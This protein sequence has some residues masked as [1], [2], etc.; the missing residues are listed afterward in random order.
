MEPGK[1]LLGLPPLKYIYHFI[2]EF[3]FAKG[4]GTGRESE[5]TFWK[6]KRTNIR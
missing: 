4:H 6:Q 1:S 2:S 5:P 3:T